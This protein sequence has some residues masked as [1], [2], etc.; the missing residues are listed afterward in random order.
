[1]FH[2]IVI[3]KHRQRARGLA[4]PSKAKVAIRILSILDPAWRNNVIKSLVRITGNN[5]GISEVPY[6][7]ISRVC[8]FLE[9]AMQIGILVPLYLFPALPSESINGQVRL[10]LVV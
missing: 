6:R 2:K 9:M 3:T 4:L 5:W 7:E 10:I 8:I 1:M